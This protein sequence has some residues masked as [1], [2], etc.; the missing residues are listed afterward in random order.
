MPGLLSV[1]EAQNYYGKRPRQPNPGVHTCDQSTVTTSGRTAGWRTSG[2]FKA[3]QVDGPWSATCVF[4]Y[5]DLRDSDR[6]KARIKINQSFQ[7]VIF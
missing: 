5:T 2:W 7:I 3:D 1:T 6:F 4:R